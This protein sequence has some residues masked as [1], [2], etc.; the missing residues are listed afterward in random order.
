MDKYAKNLLLPEDGI[1]STYKYLVYLVAFLC[2]GFEMPR[3]IYP[4]YSEIRGK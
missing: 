3:V 4:A 2:K 1:Q